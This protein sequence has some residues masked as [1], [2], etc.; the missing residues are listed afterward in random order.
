M[1]IMGAMICGT[2]GCDNG[3]PTTYP[4]SG[5]IHFENGT[6]A[7]TGFVELVPLKGGPSARGQIDT[8]GKFT[9]GTFEQADGAIAGDYVAVIIQHTQPVSAED[10]RRLGPEHE[11][12]AGANS[13][14]ALKYSSPKSSDLKCSI[15]SATDNHLAFVVEHQAVR[16][17]TE[18]VKDSE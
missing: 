10:A 17:P 15:S 11:Q 5:T 3:G 4:A 6:P 2:L 12:H 8:Q 13:L 16:E 1:V 18:E 14:V 7:R 9:L